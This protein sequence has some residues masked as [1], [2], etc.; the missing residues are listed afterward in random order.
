MATTD[1]APAPR[2]V[3]L[4]FPKTGG[5]ALAQLLVPLMGDRLAVARAEQA[6]VDLARYDWVHGHLLYHQ[7]ERLAHR[8]FTM[9]MLRNPVERILSLYRFHRRRPDDPV[10]ELANKLSFHQFV[11]RGIGTNT[12]LDMLAGDVDGSRRNDPDRIRVASRRLDTFDFVGITENFEYS[13][14]LLA[15]ELG[16]EPF[17]R[18]G[19]A[20]SA[21]S[22]TRRA[23]IDPDTIALI[24]QEA[25]ADMKIYRRAVRLFR[26]R[27]ADR[28]ALTPRDHR[29]D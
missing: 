25:A 27:L 19:H 29:A 10:H 1:T 22:P 17:W 24:K 4:H 23:D 21:P 14:L 28:F 18:I 9:T 16:V 13:A 15:A 7:I 11:E 6:E 12:Y 26:T 2:L 8:P 3:Y 20:N 5:T